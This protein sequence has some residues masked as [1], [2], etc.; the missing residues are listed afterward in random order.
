MR[1]SLVI[2]SLNSPQAW[3]GWGCFTHRLGEP[4]PINDWYVWGRLSMLMVHYGYVNS[5]EMFK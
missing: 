3:G 2:S 4:G 1:A 5:T